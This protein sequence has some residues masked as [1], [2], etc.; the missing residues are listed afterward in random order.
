MLQKQRVEKQRQTKAEER[1]AKQLYWK[2]QREL[3][4]ACEEM[5]TWYGSDPQALRYRTTPEPL[6]KRLRE[7]IEGVK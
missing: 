4:A 2:K 1:E 3:R 5:V 6:M 7:A